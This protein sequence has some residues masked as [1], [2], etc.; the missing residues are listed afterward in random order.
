MQPWVSFL[1]EKKPGIL[2]KLGELVGIESGSYDKHG[3]D[4][5]GE[6]VAA[7]LDRLNFAIDVRPNPELGNLMIGRKVYGGKGRVLILAHLDTVWPK[8]TL[9]DW[10][11]AVTRDGF[12]TGPGVGDMKGGLIVALTAIEALMALGPCL[13]QAITVLL[14]PDEELGSI[15]SRSL[16]EEEAREADWALVMEPARPNGA[17]VTARGALASFILKAEGR[18]AH[19]GSNYSTGISAVRELAGKVEAIEALS[20]PEDFRI[21]NIGIFRGGEARQVIP[22]SAEMHIDLRASNDHEIEWLMEKLKEIALTPRNPGVRLSLEGGQTRPA[23][24]R[25]ASVERLYLLAAGIAQQMQILLP[26]V[27]SSGGSDGNFTAA[28]GIPTL[29][30]LG[31]VAWDICSRQERISVESLYQK[32]RLLFELMAALPGQ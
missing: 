5:V 30:G 17:V 32:S 29:D 18:T 6:F 15:H 25:S 3:V 14:V 13:L 2:Q 8:G 1:E 27:Y 12:A 24:V 26:E 11:Y 20:R 28:M 19:C 16:I 7:E 23:F 31:P 10:P 4:Q 9:K 22:G 21:A